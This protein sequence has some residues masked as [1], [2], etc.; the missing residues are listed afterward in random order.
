MLVDSEI[1]L[2]TRNGNTKVFINIRLSN[3]NSGLVN[4]IVINTEHSSRWLIVGK[5]G[6]GV[7]CCK[8][9]SNSNVL[10]CETRGK[11]WICMGESVSAPGSVSECVCPLDLLQ[12][13]IL[14]EQLSTFHNVLGWNENRQGEGIQM[15]IT[16]C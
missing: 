2:S 13:L 1:D 16:T 3:V 5:L 7:R 8:C 12:N 6:Q 9:N 11:V 15:T 10:V 4:K 14:D